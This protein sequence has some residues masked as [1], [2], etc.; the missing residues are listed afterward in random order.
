MEADV[1][2]KCAPHSIYIYKHTHTHTHLPLE[3]LGGNLGTGGTGDEGL[4]HLAGLKVA[5]GLDVVPLFLEE[6]VGAVVCV[7]IYK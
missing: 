7:C 3:S 2:H 1:L 4:P 6:R 5:G